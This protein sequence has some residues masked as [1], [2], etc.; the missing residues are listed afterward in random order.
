M[1]A[2]IGAALT[3]VLLNYTLIP[4]FGVLGCAWAT[5]GSAFV[6]LS[7]FYFQLRR[8][9]ILDRSWLLMSVLASLFGSILLSVTSNIAVA[10]AGLLCVATIIVLFHFESL[11]YTYKIV[12]GRLAAE[13][14]PQ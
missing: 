12:K 8:R 14:W 7:L 11:D 13:K 3:N 4:K 9:T 5:V 6:H 1:Y 10:T 2:S